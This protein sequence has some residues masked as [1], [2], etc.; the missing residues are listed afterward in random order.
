MS[1]LNMVLLGAVILLCGMVT[2]SA[3]T[4]FAAR[5]AVVLDEEQARRWRDDFQRARHLKRGR[6]SRP[7][8][9]LW[10]QRPE[11]IARRASSIEQIFHMERPPAL[12]G[13]CF[14]ISLA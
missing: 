3:A 5:R 9:H 12:T 8:P 1:A 10:T 7:L 6:T 2:G 14:S 4:L 13:R 11:A